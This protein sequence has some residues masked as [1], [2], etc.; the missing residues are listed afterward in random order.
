MPSTPFITLIGGDRLAIYDANHLQWRPRG[1]VRAFLKLEMAMNGVCDVASGWLRRRCC[2]DSRL[3]WGC[4]WWLACHV[5]LSG[6]RADMAWITLG[7]AGVMIRRIW[8]A[9]NAVHDRTDED[10]RAT[11]VVLPRVVVVGGE[12]KPPLSIEVETHLLLAITIY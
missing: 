8:V 10:G 12:M 9:H 4:W 11:V 1:H 3:Q 2:H 5:L 7:V 6:A